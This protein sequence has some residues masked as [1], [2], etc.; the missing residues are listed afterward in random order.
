MKPILKGLGI[1]QTQMVF[2]LK[3]N[4]GSR[5]RWTTDDISNYNMVEIID[6]DD[7]VL[8]E[9]TLPVLMSLLKRNIILEPLIFKK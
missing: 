2:C 5:L 8:Y 9:K 4:E 3:N 1:S 7:N 6:P